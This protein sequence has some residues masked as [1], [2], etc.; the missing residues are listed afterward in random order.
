MVCIDI[1]MVYMRICIWLSPTIGRTVAA[2]W[3]SIHTVQ[4]QQTNSMSKPTW[5]SAWRAFCGMQGHSFSL[6]ALLLPSGA[7]VLLL[8]WAHQTDAKLTHARDTADSSVGTRVGSWKSCEKVKEWTI[9]KNNVLLVHGRTDN[10]CFLPCWLNFGS[11]SFVVQANLNAA[12]V[13]N[14]LQL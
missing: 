2:C 7:T 5:I 6:P 9:W 13:G 3:L 12:I 11:S 10:P 1:H 4:R 8:L 14:E